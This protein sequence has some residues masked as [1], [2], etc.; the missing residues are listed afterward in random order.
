MKLC[1]FVFSW[2]RCEHRVC[3]CSIAWLSRSSRAIGDRRRVCGEFSRKLLNLILNRTWKPNLSFLRT[4]VKSFRVEARRE[5]WAANEMRSSRK[6][7]QCCVQVYATTKLHQ[8]SQRLN[9]IIADDFPFESNLIS[10][11][12]E[13]MIQKLSQRCSTTFPHVL[14][15][16]FLSIIS[17]SEEDEVG[18]R[19]ATIAASTPAST[20]MENDRR[21]LLVV[22]SVVVKLQHQT[23]A[24]LHRY[25]SCGW[26]LPLCV[27]V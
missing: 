27:A 6:R 2:S 18:E 7:Q 16:C 8:L 21:K 24:E 4:I 9:D 5:R 23:A 14:F 12:V 10:F 3:M 26:E 13:Q 15:N 19:K 17:H 20:C 22:E 11:I 1:A 25:I